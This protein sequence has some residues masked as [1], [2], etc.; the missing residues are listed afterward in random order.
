VAEEAETR[1]VRRREVTVE[2]TAETRTTA[3][4]T[5]EATAEA[6]MTAA[7]E[8]GTQ[9]VR[10]EGALEVSRKGTLE[11][12]RKATLEGTA[13]TGTTAVVGT[14]GAEVGA[15]DMNPKATLEVP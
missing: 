2:G 8:S 1:Q 5:L 15:L 7:E 9:E 3:E 10:R 6:G 12:G 13:E 11:V 4:A 14:A